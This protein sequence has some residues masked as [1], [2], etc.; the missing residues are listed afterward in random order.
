MMTVTDITILEMHGAHMIVCIGLVVARET[1]YD[2]RET[3]ETTVN[4][5][6]GIATIGGLSDEKTSRDAMIHTKD[7]Q[8][9]NPL[10][11]L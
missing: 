2:A 4:S 11:V 5:T 1:L 10:C 6:D 8:V 9:S 7:P 3:F